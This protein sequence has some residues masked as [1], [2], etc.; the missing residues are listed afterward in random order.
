MC[1]LLT[2]HNLTLSI[3]DNKNNVN[4]LM[5]MQ[6]LLILIHTVD[7]RSTVWIFSHFVC[8]VRV[9]PFIAINYIDNGRYSLGFTLIYSLFLNGDISLHFSWDA[10]RCCGHRTRINRMSTTFNKYFF[11]MKVIG[12]FMMLCKPCILVYF[13]ITLILVHII[14]GCFHWTTHSFEN[15]NCLLCIRLYDWKL[16]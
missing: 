5:A 8:Q 2:S 16:Y 9:V 14:K 15:I 6:R 1:F 7:D 12:K 4:I 3:S 13:E 11:A 10:G